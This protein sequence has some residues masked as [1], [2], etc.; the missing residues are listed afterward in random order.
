[1]AIEN[2]IDLEEVLQEGDTLKH[3]DKILVWK[4]LSLSR[5]ISMGMELDE[6]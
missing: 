3:G 4:N 5:K 2:F 6:F 1:M